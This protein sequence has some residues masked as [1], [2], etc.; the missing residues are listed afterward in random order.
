MKKI[1]KEEEE[2]CVALIQK[3]L[4]KLHQIGPLSNSKMNLEDLRVK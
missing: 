3:N 1:E 4:I 2:S